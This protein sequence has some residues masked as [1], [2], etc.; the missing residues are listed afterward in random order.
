MQQTFSSRQLSSA[1][2]GNLYQLQ[3]K[4]Y[5]NAITLKSLACM[6]TNM[7]FSNVILIAPNRAHHVAW[8]I[9]RRLLDLPSKLLTQNQPLMVNE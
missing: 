5:Q 2:L 1:Q 3:T 6:Y 7:A 4:Y 8:Y 9:R